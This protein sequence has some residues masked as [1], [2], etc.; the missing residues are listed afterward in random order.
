MKIIVV[1]ANSIT[2]VETQ[3]GDVSGHILQTY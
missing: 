1:V 3:A 2:I